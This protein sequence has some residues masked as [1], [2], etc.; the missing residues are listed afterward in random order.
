ANL[1]APQQ[2]PLVEE[3]LAAL[4]AKERESLILHYFQD[5]SYPQIAAL[6]GIEEAAARKRVSR[7]LQRLEAQMR[8]RGLGVSATGFFA[9]VAAQQSS[10]ATQA[11]LAGVAIAGGGVAGSASAT[12]GSA[13]PLAMMISTFMSHTPL[14][15]AACTIAIV[16]APLIW[17]TQANASLRAQL[18]ERR[19]KQTFASPQTDLASLQ[20]EHARLRNAVASRRTARVAEENR[21]AALGT[22]EKKL[23]DEVVISFGTVD[24]MARK[25]AKVLALMEKL[26]PSD[27][28]AAQREPLSNEERVRIANEISQ[29]VPEM[30]SLVRE[31]PKLEREPEKA[32]R[33]Y[34]TMLGEIWKCDDA[35]RTAIEP[36]IAHWVERLQADGLTLVQRPRGKASDW[37]TRRNAATGELLT[38]LAATVPAEKRAGLP[39][40]QIFRGG[41]DPGIYE[42]LTAPNDP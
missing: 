10:I 34:A 2:W 20:Q 30:M 31:V 17:Q 8:K 15:I 39:L 42:F 6:L 1:R 16:V 37:D 35:T 7:A 4:A 19:P 33:F 21:A 22:F 41:I 25:L 11:S 13:L 38:G 9:S 24:T 27:K 12:T 18:R 28:S 32:G 14:K 29:A 40:D 36:Q 23:T 26:D 3:A 5:L